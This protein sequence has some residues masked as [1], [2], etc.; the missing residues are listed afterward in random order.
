M[1][2]IAKEEIEYFWDFVSNHIEDILVEPREREKDTYIWLG[3]NVLDDFNDAYQ[4]LCEDGGYDVSIVMNGIFTKAS[5]LLS[6]C[7]IENYLD[8]W[9][10]R[11]R[12][13]EKRKDWARNMY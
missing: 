5:D 2:D 8:V 7:G 12:N 9:K 3:F 10:Q 1:R 11:P 4:G 13:I 6:G